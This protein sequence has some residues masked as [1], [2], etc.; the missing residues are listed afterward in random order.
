MENYTVVLQI[1]T[2][3]KTIVLNTHDILKKT[4]NYFVIQENDRIIV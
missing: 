3:F 1:F 2:G 4:C